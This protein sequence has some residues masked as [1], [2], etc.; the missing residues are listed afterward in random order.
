MLELLL[1]LPPAPR[2]APPDR[3]G[4]GRGTT[5]HAVSEN[6][7]EIYPPRLTMLRIHSVLLLLR[8]PSR[9]CGSFRALESCRDPAK[10]RTLHLSRISA[11]QHWIA[12]SLARST[13]S[14]TVPLD[15]DLAKHCEH[16]ALIF[17]WM[18]KEKNY[19]SISH[20]QRSHLEGLAEGRGRERGRKKLSRS[21][22][23]RVLLARRLAG[24][25]DRFQKKMPDE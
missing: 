9:A 24:N 23:T 19:R 13:F 3:D 2:Y 21:S 17:R 25:G 20:G 5:L 18:K 14:T 22:G 4:D 16:F 6:Q 11:R 1:S 7:R 15:F 8:I 12:R 10:S